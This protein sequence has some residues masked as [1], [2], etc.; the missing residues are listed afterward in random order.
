MTPTEPLSSSA[1][2]SSVATVKVT[3]VDPPVRSTILMPRFPE[4]T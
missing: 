2:S 4:V 3:L 1:L